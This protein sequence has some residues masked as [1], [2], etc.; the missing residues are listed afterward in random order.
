[1]FDGP[2]MLRVKWPVVDK[3][4]PTSNKFATGV[5]I[6]ATGELKLNV[7]PELKPAKALEGNLVVLLTSLGIYINQTCKFLLSYP[8]SSCI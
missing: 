2:L 8:M 6:K 4:H 1:M 5:K 3:I 7:S